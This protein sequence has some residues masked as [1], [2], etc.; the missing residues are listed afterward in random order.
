MY[1]RKV[2]YQ[3]WRRIRDAE[4][5]VRKNH[6]KSQ[7]A[8]IAPTNS[9]GQGWVWSRAL[10]E[11][12]IEADAF[13]ITSNEQ[14]FFQADR[15][16]QRTEWIEWDYRVSLGEEIG[17]KYSHIFLESLRPLLGYHKTAQTFTIENVLEDIQLFKRSKRKV[18]LIFHGSD[19][20]DVDFHIKKSPFSPFSSK[21]PQAIAEVEQLRKRSAEVRAALPRLRRMR[22][23]IFVTTPDLFHEAPHATWL[24]VAINTLPFEEVA[25]KAPAFAHG[26][27]PRVL[28]LP[29]S[30]WIKSADII[31]PILEKLDAEGVITRVRTEKVNH[32]QVPSLM[33]KADIVIDQFLGIIGALPLEAMAAERL[34]LTHIA[35]WTHSRMPVIPPV[36]DITPE[37]LESVLRSISH[38]RNHHI[39]YLDTAKKYVLEYHD[40]RKS[41]EVLSQLFR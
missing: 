39:D 10:R 4:H 37:T 5:S 8:L 26:G 24:P 41:A 33:A 13:R 17:T 18:A 12:G 9:A 20:R 22:I 28:Y 38:D 19:I 31:E 16:I 2:D 11:A 6:P 25:R 23:P 15:T 35:P 7:R 14:D 27:Q 21:N 1:R 3:K 29:S 34:V 30:S 40:G 36:I 32:S